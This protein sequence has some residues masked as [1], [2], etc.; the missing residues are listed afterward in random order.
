[1]NTE[2]KI[3]TEAHAMAH[4]AMTTKVVNGQLVYVLYGVIETCS[5]ADACE[6]LFDRRETSREPETFAL[7]TIV[8]AR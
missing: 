2:T 6:L 8:T 5:L 7:L 4:T 3:S 1:M